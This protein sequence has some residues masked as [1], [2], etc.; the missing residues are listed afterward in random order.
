MPRKVNDPMNRAMA[1]KDDEFYTPLS[2][3]KAEL[4]HYPKRLFVGKKILC[5]CDDPGFDRND[6]GVSEFFRYFDDRFEELRLK[7]LVGLRYS[8]SSLFDGI[9]GRAAAYTRKIVADKKGKKRYTPKRFLP[10]DSG[11]FSDREGIRQLKE[12][13]IVITNPPFSRLREF[14][15]LMMAS[16]KKF[17]IIGN[18]NAVGYKEIFPLIE[19][20]KMW[21]GSARPNGKFIRPDGSEASASSYWFTNIPHDRREKDFLRLT[22]KYTAKDYP[23]YDNYPAIEVGKTANIPADYD[24]EMGVPRSFIEKHNPKQ[25][26]IVGKM[27]FPRPGWDRVPDLLLR[28]KLVAD[29]LL[30]KRISAADEWVETKDLSRRALSVAGGFVYVMTNP[31]FPGSYKIG[32]TNKSVESRRKSLSATGNRKP[33]KVVMALRVNNAGQAEKQVHKK[34]APYRES[35]GTEFFN[36]PREHLE[37]VLGE[38]AGKKLRLWK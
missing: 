20:G 7:Q 1:A 31:D 2:M 33:F 6:P 14:I 25:F 38:L 23:T 37:K 26:E 30:I 32:K 4:A 19:G 10:G 16:G 13:D 18:L 35:K 3:I 15:K 17:I 5:N 29:R 27:R 34:L 9:S 21:L 28:N 12:C 11:G 36:P 8:G 22:K 24:G